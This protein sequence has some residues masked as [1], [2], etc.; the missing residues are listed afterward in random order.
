[1]RLRISNYYQSW[2]DSTNNKVTIVPKNI[3]N[4]ITTNNNDCLPWSEDCAIKKYKFHANPIKHYRKQYTNINSSTTTFSKLSLIGSLDK[5]GNNINSL[6]NE[7]DCTTLNNISNLNI[8]TN[9]DILTD[10]TSDSCPAA[11][12]IKRANTKLANNYSS[13]HREYLYSKCK[14]FTQN[15]P[16]QY[17]TII[18]NGI[19]LKVCNDVSSCV[20]YNPSNKSFQTQGPVSSSARTHSLKY[21]CMDGSSCNKKV[22]IN[23]CPNNI[24]LQECLRLKN[25]LNS[26]TPVCVGCINE[27]NTIRRK[28]INI[29]K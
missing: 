22:S 15:L 18:N 24:S 12:V 28:R 3:K 13:S 29:L 26:P 27:P 23:N 10:C 16:L 2:K 7:N 5:P 20:I 4:T 25:L 11:L 14:T 9:F 19:Q 8:I 1:M 21:G 6:I 17:D